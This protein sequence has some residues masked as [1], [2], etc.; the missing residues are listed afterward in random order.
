MDFTKYQHVERYG[1]RPVEGIER[2][3]CWV[4]PKIDGSNGCV[5][6]DGGAVR[7]GGRNR[8]LSAQDGNQGFYGAVTADPRIAG[9]LGKLPGHILYGEWLVPHTLRT[10]RQDA[11][12]KFYIFDVMEN[13]VY[14]P[15]EEYRPLLEEFGLDYIPLIAS[16]ENGSIE[17]FAGC[18]DK[19]GFLIDSG[20]GEGVVIKNYDFRSPVS[21]KQVWAK[22]LTAE[23]AEKRGAQPGQTLSAE[24]RIIN[25]FVTADFVNKEYAKLTEDG[26]WS[27][28]M[29]PKLFSTVFRVL[30]SEE[31]L[32]IIDAYKQP[33]VN[34]RTL[35]YLVNEKVKQVK[36]ELFGKK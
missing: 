32:N 16:F 14:I 19:T 28:K 35:A 21:G 11:W 4:F 23:F 7:A 5:W 20:T 29:T 24:Q 6:S 26:G 13:G 17:D 31:M 12:K 36:P 1:M 10:Y 15:Y 8:E 9:Y 34:F 25:D 3:K 18:L 30:V 27:P 22:I 2:G 33:T